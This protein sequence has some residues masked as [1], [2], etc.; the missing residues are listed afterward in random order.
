LFIK[1]FFIY[2]LSD[3]QLDPQELYQAQGFR[4]SFWGAKI[5]RHLENKPPPRSWRMGISVV[6]VLDKFFIFFV[7]QVLIV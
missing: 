2:L 5:K 4:Q 1:G 6:V 3:P 7:E